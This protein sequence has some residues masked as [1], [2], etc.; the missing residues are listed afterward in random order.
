M[1]YRFV[2]LTIEQVQQIA[3]WQ[4]P[5]AAVGIYTDPYFASYRAGESPLRGPDGCLGY[6]ALS[7]GRLVGLFEY[8]LR[9]E[10]LEIGLALAPEL[11][12]QGHGCSF[13]LAGLQ[14]GIAELG[15]PGDHVRLQVDQD[16]L[17]AIRV[18]QQVGFREVGRQG[19]EIL[20]HWRTPGRG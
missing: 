9:P 8:Y 6:A 20:M 18:Y 12:G 10:A 2:P 11:V 16:N 4:Y 14:F 5:D 3:T 1:D 13:V 15:C 17:P 19:R 7:S